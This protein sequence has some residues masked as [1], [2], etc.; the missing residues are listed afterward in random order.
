[1]GYELGALTMLKIYNSLTNQVETFK[2]NQANSVNMYV[3]GPTVYDDIHIGNG[4]PVVFFDVLKRYLRF[5]GFK[6][7]YATNI[8]D[9]DDRIIAKA[10][11]TNQTEKDIAKKFSEAFF[12][13]VKNTGSEIP[14]L[15]PYATHYLTEMVTYIQKLIDTDYAYVKPSGV[16]FRV[17][18]VNDYGMLSNQKIDELRKGVRIDLE[19]DKEDTIDFA[20]W[21]FTKEG[22]TY[23]APWGMGRP[24]WHTECA[25]MNDELFGDQLDIHGGGF[26]LKFPHHENE[27]AQSQAHSHHHLANYW[28]HVGRLD[29]GSE[30]MSKSL[31]NVIK[32]KDLL[33]SYDAGSYRFMLLAH[34]YRNP[35]HFSDELMTQYQ[36][37]Y[38]KISYTINRL[39]FY[40]SAEETKTDEKDQALL[41]A[42]I[43]LMDDDFKTPA[44]VTLLDEA[45]KTLN[46]DKNQPLLNSVLTILSVLG[47]EPKVNAFTNEDLKTYHAWKQ[48]R[49]NKNYQLA[50][51]LR[52]N[53]VEKGWI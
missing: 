24:G 4:R 18:K 7:T 20:L 37:T 1:M 42:F 44:V 35:I 3:C 23:D 32:V 53:L 48:A 40:F 9:V 45:V 16:Y 51:T 41:D 28:M 27:I 17:S 21:K 52:Q 10:I 46:K 36:K 39:S 5:R 6:V 29:M 49:D 2:P 31:G 8:T 14:D 25:V 19:E 15:T 11:N 50:D 47:I 30:K 33:A 34:H 26:D 22:I 12:D 43:K 38:D 13:V